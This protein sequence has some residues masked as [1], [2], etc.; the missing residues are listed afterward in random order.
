M[1]QILS[2]NYVRCALGVLCAVL[3]YMGVVSNKTEDVSWY[4]SF[5]NQLEVLDIKS[6][7]L[8]FIWVQGDMGSVVRPIGGDDAQFDA[9]RT[10]VESLLVAACDK[11]R[12]DRKT[13]VVVELTLD[14]K[15]YVHHKDLID[16]WKKRYPKNFD[17][18][19][20]DQMYD[21]YPEISWALDQ[22]HSGIPALCSDV[23]RLWHLPQDYDMNVYMDVD[24]FVARHS[25]QMRLSSALSLGSRVVNRG[26]YHGVQSSS[27]PKDNLCN[28]DLIIDYGSDNWPLIKATSLSALEAYKEPWQSLSN[29]ML[30]KKSY[31]GYVEDLNVRLSWW[32]SHPYLN[33]HPI[34][35]VVHVNGP[36]FWLSLSAEGHSAFYNIPL[37]PNQGSWKGGSDTSIKGSMTYGSL[38][39]WWGDRA[40]RV[41][42]LTLMASDY[43][44]LLSHNVSWK[45]QAADDI[46]SL[47]GDLTPIQRHDLIHVLKT[48]MMW[49]RS[50]ADSSCEAM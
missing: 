44:Y 47:W 41:L 50:I 37:S 49:A 21:L 13:D 48:P 27:N 5:F 31:E 32:E 38:K 16:S 23:L 45:C 22:C 20:V 6:Y 4:D 28:N 36:W 30:W 14:Q 29:R 35:M 11:K 19:F 10:H 42:K 1:D 8:L 33:F 7:R 9:W 26:V 15:S 46:R 40:N 2:N 25:D 12:H 3:L 24:T 43:Q 17:M 18:T 39:H 34:G